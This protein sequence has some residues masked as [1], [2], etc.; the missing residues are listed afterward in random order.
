MAFTRDGNHNDSNMIIMII[1]R[2]PPL[3]KRREEG[4]ALGRSCMCEREREMMGKGVERTHHG[5]GESDMVEKR[6]RE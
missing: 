3:S 2:H 4:E 1:T 6:R 5:R